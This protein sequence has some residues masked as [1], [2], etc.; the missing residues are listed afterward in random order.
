MSAKLPA[1]MAGMRPG[2]EPG[3]GAESVSIDYTN[4]YA[5]NKQWTYPT[6]QRSS[7]WSSCSS[8]WSTSYAAFTKTNPNTALVTNAPNT[9]VYASTMTE[10][11][12]GNLSMVNA[13]FSRTYKPQVLGAFT[14]IPT[15]AC[16]L[17]CTMFG[18]EVQ[19]YNWPTPAPVPPVTKLINTEGFTL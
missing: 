13:V 3:P 11:P 1:E 10:H 2:L 9:A 19:V 7:E 18:G 6:P 14:F 15:G 17:Q 5:L 8:V 12:T 4:I 16:C